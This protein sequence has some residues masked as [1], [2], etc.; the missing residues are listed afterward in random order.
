[1]C[2]LYTEWCR[3]MTSLTE[4]TC[5]NTMDYEPSTMHIYSTGKSQKHYCKWNRSCPRNGGCC[6]SQ[7]QR[8]TLCHT[9]TL[10]FSAQ[11]QRCIERLYHSVPCN[12]QVWC[13]YSSGIFKRRASIDEIGCK[14]IMRWEFRPSNTTINWIERCRV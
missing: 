4:T 10:G 7:G 1:M 12:Y 11:V 3:K 9:Q 14:Y 5:R 13:T 6:E 2:F 8:N